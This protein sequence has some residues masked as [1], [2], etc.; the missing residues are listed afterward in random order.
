MI[1][2]NDRDGK[3]VRTIQSNAANSQPGECRRRVAAWASFWYFFWITNQDLTMQRFLQTIL[4]LGAIG[5]LAGSH[6][7]HANRLFAESAG[8]DKKK[9]ETKPADD[10]T[11]LLCVGWKVHVNRELLA[12]DRVG[13]AQA[14]EILEKQLEEIVRVVPRAAVVELKKVPLW[15]SPE[16]EGVPPRA[17]YHPGAG[18]LKD[19]GRDPVMEKS[20]EF[21]NVRIFEAENRRMPLFV[22]HELAHAY[23]DRVLG[24]DHK[25]IQAAYA[26]AKAGGK[27]DLVDR[28]HA[29]GRTTKESAYALSNPQEYFAES[30]EAFFGTNDF[31]PFTRDELKTQDPEMFDLLVQLWGVR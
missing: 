10:K 21:T 23:H 6:T 16:Y 26:K 7:D 17:E 2:G 5:P 1:A 19:H 8:S 31:F 14:L 22:L 11:P 3:P 29:D 25:G 9:G 24:N 13:T 27:Y 30:T 4:L 15:I 20:V 12:K 28:R 18:W